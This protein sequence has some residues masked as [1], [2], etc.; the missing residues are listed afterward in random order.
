MM[1]APLKFSFFI[2]FNFINQWRDRLQIYIPSCGWTSKYMHYPKKETM[3]QKATTS[4]LLGEYIVSILQLCSSFT[5]NAQII[6]SHFQALSA[7]N[8]GGGP[9]KTRSF[10]VQFSN[11]SRPGKGTW[12]TL[13][14]FC[15][16]TQQCEDQSQLGCKLVLNCV[17]SIVT[18]ITIKHLLKE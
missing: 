16:S 5:M 9:L 13:S 6:S 17:G 8:A 1:L 18:S 10:L 7:H 12:G 4:S 14:T 15:P 3:T 2:L 11:A